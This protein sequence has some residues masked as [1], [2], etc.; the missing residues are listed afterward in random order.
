MRSQLSQRLQPKPPPPVVPSPPGSFK[1]WLFGTWLRKNKE[2][3]K[4]IVTLTSTGITAW[5]A[6]H[7]V[8][9]IGL[10]VAAVVGLVTSFLLDGLDFLLTGNPQ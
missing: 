9:T 5:V 6:V 4:N 1:G 8:G 3:L 2:R 10:V 7:L